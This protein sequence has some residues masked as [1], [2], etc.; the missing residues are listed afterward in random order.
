MS[1]LRCLVIGFV[2]MV[3]AAF[4]NGMQAEE[5]CPSSKT[6]PEMMKALDAAISGPADKDRTCLRSLFLPDATLTVMTADKTGVVKPVPFSVDDW[7]E[8]VKKRGSTPMY[9]RQV[10]FVTE[11]YGNIA[12]LWSLYEIH[13]TPDGPMK[14]RGVN[15][16][17][18][19]NDGA[20]WKVVE[21][22]WQA[23]TPSTPIPAELA[24]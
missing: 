7:I 16:I 8:R 20:Q 6:L 14:S 2:T 1:R 24:P 19:M 12:H 10:K 21:V 22:L 18:A 23:E 15:S 13:E 11:S 9:E 17:Q 3:L 5:V 4:A